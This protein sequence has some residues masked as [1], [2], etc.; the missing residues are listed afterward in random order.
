MHAAVIPFHDTKIIKITAV[1]AFRYTVL[2][3]SPQRG[4]SEKMKL[5][6]VLTTKHDDVW[7]SGGTDPFF[8]NLGTRRG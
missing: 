1:F 4:K 5:F 3:I 6:L 8:L 7:G 2:L